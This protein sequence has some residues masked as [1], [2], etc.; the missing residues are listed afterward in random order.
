MDYNTLL[1]LST[2]LGYELAMSGAETFRVEDS[3]NRILAAYGVES[4]VF[5]IPNCLTVSIETADGQ[6]LTRMRRIGQHGNDL[7]SLERFNGLSRAICNRTPEP[8]EGKRWLNI[9]RESRQH[10]NFP[11]YLLGNF[12]GGAGF[13]VFFGDFQKIRSLFI[14]QVYYFIV[15]T[16]TRPATARSTSASS[17][18]RYW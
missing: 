14:S 7:D 11:V 5:A 13:A 8:R 18:I 1:D 10:Y 16:S 3:I 2:D 17:T 4:E 6:L 9:V 12:I 15:T